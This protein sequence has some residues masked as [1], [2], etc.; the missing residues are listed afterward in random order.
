MFDKLTCAG[1][2]AAPMIIDESS[3]DWQLLGFTF[4]YILLKPVYVFSRRSLF[5]L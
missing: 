5:G 2:A 1:G 3:N 4:I